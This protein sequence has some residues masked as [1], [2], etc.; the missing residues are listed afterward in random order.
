MLQEIQFYTVGTATRKVREPISV[1]SFGT[2]SLS[3]SEF[4]R[5][6]RGKKYFVNAALSLEG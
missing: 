3:A 2:V 6:V 1:F 5:I 4:H